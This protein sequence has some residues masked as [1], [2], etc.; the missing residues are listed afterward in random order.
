MS[1][2][3]MGLKLELRRFRLG[4]FLV[5]GHCVSLSLERTVRS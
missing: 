5:G 4:N 3:L 1:V 2:L